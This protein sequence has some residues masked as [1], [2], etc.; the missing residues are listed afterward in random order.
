MRPAPISNLAQFFLLV[1]T[2]TES[3]HGF[4]FRAKSFFAYAT[5][6][7]DTGGVTGYGDRSLH[8]QSHRESFLSLFRHHLNP[9]TPS[10]YLFDEPESAL[11]VTGQVAFLRLLKEW[12]DSSQVQV[13]IATPSPILLAF[14]GATIYSF[15]EVR[16]NPC[17]TAKHVPISGPRHF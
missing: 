2:V 6:L 15:D 4:F 11:S 7:D 1:I 10:L 5:Y 8:Q 14:P 16:F 17:P 12:V 3:R 13:I 9:L